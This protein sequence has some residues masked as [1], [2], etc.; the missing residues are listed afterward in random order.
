MDTSEREFQT[1]L[2]WLNLHNV[3]QLSGLTLQTLPH[4]ASLVLGPR[5]TH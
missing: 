1:R 5:I 2:L 4:E 3:F